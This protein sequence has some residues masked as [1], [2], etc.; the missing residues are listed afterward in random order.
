MSGMPLRRGLIDAELLIAMRSGHPDAHRFAVAM[1]RFAV[2]EVSELSAMILLVRCPSGSDL[3]RELGFLGH[4]RVHRISAPISGRACRIIGSMP[5]PSP[6]S[7]DDAIV[8]ATAVIHK[9]PLYTLD[10][11]RFAAVP[12]LSATRPY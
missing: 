2:L 1:L 8:A 3:Q 5:P 12:G 11:A 9:L 4:S 10:P 6:L 7:A